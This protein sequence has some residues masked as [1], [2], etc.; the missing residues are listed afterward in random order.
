M[1]QTET[2]NAEWSNPENWSAGLYFSKKDS[3]T[4]VPKSVPWMGWTLNLAKRAGAFWMLGLL[5]GLPVL[6]ILLM[7]MTNG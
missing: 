6:I 3:R 2:N 5:V 7:S 4:W 1:N